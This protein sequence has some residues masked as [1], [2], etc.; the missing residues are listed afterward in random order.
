[1]PLAGH[2]GVLVALVPAATP[3]TAADG[4]LQ[5]GRLAEL[6]GIL[7]LVR[8]HMDFAKIHCSRT[9]LH[10]RGAF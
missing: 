7:L 9:Y 2:L 1:M 6:D 5:N 10:Y 8:N 4:A 3:A